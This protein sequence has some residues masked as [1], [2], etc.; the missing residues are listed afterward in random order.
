MAVGQVERPGQVVALALALA[1]G[2]DRLAVDGHEL[3]PHDRVEFQG[4]IHELGKGV[5]LVALDVE[6][7]DIGG[8]LGI[9]LHK[10]GIQVLFDQ[11]NGVDEGQGGRQGHQDGRGGVAR[12]EQPADGLTH[13]QMAC[14]KA[15]QRF[16]KKPGAEEGDTDEHQEAADEIRPRYENLQVAREPDRRR[17]SWSAPRSA[18]HREAIGFSAFR[19]GRGPMA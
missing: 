15:L 13:R 12:P 4:A 16:Q 18:N 7:K 10:G 6:K 8:V 11:E 19:A 3:G 2:V 17:R 1:A 9:G 5:G 14:R